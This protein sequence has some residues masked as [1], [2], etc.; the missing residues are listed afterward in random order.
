MGSGNRDPGNG[1]GKLGNM[2]DHVFSLH[3]T[4][5]LRTLRKEL[6]FRH[7]WWPRAARAQGS[8]QSNIFSSYFVC[9][10]DGRCAS[11]IFSKFFRISGPAPEMQMERAGQ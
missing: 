9:S 2:V 5:C 6:D 11:R 4:R 8:D 3:L 1:M 10:V 7:L